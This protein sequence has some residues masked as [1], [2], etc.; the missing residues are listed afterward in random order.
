MLKIN[1]ICWNQVCKCWKSSELST[2]LHPSL[3]AFLKW[4]L[5]YMTALDL[6]SI[7]RT[8]FY[9]VAGWT[10]RSARAGMNLF[11]EMIWRFFHQQ[12]SQNRLNM[13]RLLVLKRKCFQCLK[14]LQCFGVQYWM[15]KSIE[16]DVYL[17]KSNLQLFW[18]FCEIIPENLS[19]FHIH[20]TEKLFFF[21]SCP[22][23]CAV[24][25]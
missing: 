19:Y 23:L 9:L 6:L 5:E 17:L 1:C 10:G 4:K 16:D 12:M 2:V 15:W 22:F 18:R 7:Q 14:W 25:P 20:D 3:M 11:L 13:C 8:T 21:N 24:F